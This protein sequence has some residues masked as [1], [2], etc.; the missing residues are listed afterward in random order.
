[1]PGTVLASVPMNVEG[2]A[3]L[4]FAFPI[5]L[6][7]VIASVLYVLLFG[8]PHPRVPPRRIAAPAVAGSPAS[9]AAR[10]A[11]IAHGMPTAAGG[12]SVESAA[13]PEGAVRETTTT[14]GSSNV[15]GE[16]AGDGGP[17]TNTEEGTEA[18]E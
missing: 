13:E 7:A 8:R 18:S 14:S 3:Y 15:S 12:G 9:G 11:A 6:F 5:I 4:T 10:A 16:A 17:D 1:M 2:G